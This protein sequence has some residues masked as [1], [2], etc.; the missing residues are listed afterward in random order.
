MR[1]PAP[2]LRPPA[3]ERSLDLPAALRWG[4]EGQHLL[5]APEVLEE[6]ARQAPLDGAEAWIPRARAREVEVLLEVLADGRLPAA[7]LRERIGE[8]PLDVQQILA[9]LYLRWLA[10]VPEGGG[11][12]AH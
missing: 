3:A 9:H 5:F 2:T 11:E 4:L 10:T 8:A 12:R 1:H 6:A 7:A